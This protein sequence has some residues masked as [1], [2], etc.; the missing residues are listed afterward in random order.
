[1]KRIILWL[2]GKPRVLAATWFSMAA[3]LVTFALGGIMGLITGSVWACI[4]TMF[5]FFSASLVI[6]AGLLLLTSIEEGWAFGIGCG[7]YYGTILGAG[8]L[9]RADAYS[10]AFVIAALIC[11]ILYC[12][13]HKSE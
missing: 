10:V 11:Y 8:L 4:T 9:R 7:L 13:F 6:T 2:K 12:K 1:M 3:A 5:W